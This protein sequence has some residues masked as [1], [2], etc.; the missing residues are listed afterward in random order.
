MSKI[1]KNK[2]VKL[3]KNIL[4]CQIQKNREVKLKKILRFQLK[5]I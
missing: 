1:T 4:R 3:K 5:T 2:G